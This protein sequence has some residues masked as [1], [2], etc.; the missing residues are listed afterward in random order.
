[1]EIIQGCSKLHMTVPTAVAIGK[2][3]GVHVGHRKLITRILQKKKEG[4][5]ACIFTFDPP[6][7]VFFGKRPGKELTTREEKRML[8]R[9]LG[10]D[11]LIEFPLQEDT[12]AIPPEDF[13]KSILAEQLHAGFVAAG[14]DL[15]FGKNGAGNRE[16][17]CNM[18]KEC[19]FDVEI[20]EK[21]CNK[22]REVSS[23]YVREAVTAGNMELAEEL[24][25]EPFT[26]FGEVVHG[27]QLG[28][29]LGM[30][31]INQLPP[32]NKLLPPFGVYFSE[33]EMEGRVYKGITN[34]GK[35]PTVNLGETVGVE[36][37]LYNFNQ[38]VYG[39]PAQVRLLSFKRPEKK[40]AD[41]ESLKKQIKED[42]EAGLYYRH[43]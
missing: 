36:T 29:T 20:I 22:G 43:F 41:V 40:F 13:V 9:K 7:D 10:V 31:T 25:G 38:D 1:M 39:D 3:D 26:V 14:T 28:R 12:A 42:V 18:Q 2:F 4:L 21:V 27:N 33:V 32:E 24:L 6:P 11:Y 35:K 16:L 30:P 37:F 19:G 17:L 5:A 23:T 8:F 34:I 15:S